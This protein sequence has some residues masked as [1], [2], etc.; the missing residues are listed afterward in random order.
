M[1]TQALCSL[2]GASTSYL[3]VCVLSVFC[4]AGASSA[5]RLAVAEGVWVVAMVVLLQV[6]VCTCVC[7]CVCVCVS[8][9]NND[10][11]GLCKNDGRTLGSHRCDS[12]ALQGGERAR[13]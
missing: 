4:I 10:V 7:V 2:H 1:E 5:W 3:A 13:K 11:G 8:C 9:G 6:R 12:G